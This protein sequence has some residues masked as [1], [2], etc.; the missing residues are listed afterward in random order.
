MNLPAEVYVGSFGYALGDRRFHVEESA[1]AGRLR[2]SSRDLREAGFDLHHV[3]D[4]GTSAYDLAKAAVKEIASLG[5]T[6][7]IVYA[8]CLPLNANAGDVSA[9]AES[10]DV[11]CLMDFPAG[12]LQADLD[13]GE[14]IVVGL[15]Q[16][17]CTSMLGSLRV[18]AALLATEPD[19]ERV[20]CVTADR[21]PEGALYEQAFN[22]ISDGAAAC[23]VGREPAEFRLV[24]VHQIS[25]GRLGQATDEVTV[26]TYF[27]YTHRLVQE[28]LDRAG[29][30]IGDIDWVVPQNTH[31]TAWRILARLLGV[32][33]AKV[34]FPSM[35]RVGHVISADNV[36]NVSDLLAS[37]QVRPGQRVALVMAGFGLTWQCAILEATE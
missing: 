29:L 15:G 34:W 5:R 37:G 21:F 4:P 26:G 13:L 2:S 16:Q 10:R 36:V 11:K 14:P 23:V 12:R 22:L 18:A 19:W 28:T 25:N 24:T 20:L 33:E 8:T 27:A 3:C 30:T 6:D 17:A 9:L 35:P 32:D 1:A 7:A 31:V